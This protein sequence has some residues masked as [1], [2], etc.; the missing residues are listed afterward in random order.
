MSGADGGDADWS[1]G[2][3]VYEGAEAAPNG[4]GAS[5]GPKDG[6]GKRLDDDNRL[7]QQ[8]ATIDEARA[9][10]PSGNAAA[11]VPSLEPQRVSA[12]RAAS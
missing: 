6:A 7:A 9:P 10:H 4:G 3:D 12:P 8:R 5:A 2:G 1:E 11:D